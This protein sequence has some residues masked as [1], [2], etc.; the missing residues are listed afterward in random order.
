MLYKRHRRMIY[1][2]LKMK[3]L[4][5]VLGL[6]F[7]F[8][9]T[10]QVDAKAGKTLFRNYCAQCHDKTMVKDMTGPAL[11]GAQ[12]RWGDDEALYGWI[13]NSAA[14]IAS[15]YP[16]AVKLYS[17]WDASNMTAFPDLTDDQVGSLLA[18]VNGVADGTFGPPPPPPE[19]PNNPSSKK[20]SSNGMWYWILFACLAALALILLRVIGNLDQL[21]AEKEGKPY[22]RKSL[23]ESITSS[24]LVSILIF[25]LVILAGYTTVNN[26][27]NLG[28]QQNYE[29]DQPIAFSH[30]THAGLHKI[31]CQY[32][33][34]GARRSKHAVIPATNT[35]MNCHAAIKVGSQ[36]GTAELSK[37]YA[38]AGWNP[39]S[40]K[41]I[42]GYDEMSQDE[43]KAIFSKWITD[44]YKEENEI[45][46]LDDNDM[47]EIESQWNNIVTSLT[48]EQKKT[49]QGPIEWTRVHNLPDHVYFNHAQHVTAGKIECQTCHGAV[50]EMEVLK[51]D[52]PLSMGWCINC[53]RQTEVQ[54]NDNDYY[55]DYAKYH[56]EI[57]SGERE[58]VT[59]AD[60]GGLECQKCHY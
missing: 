58:K 56:E 24:G 30:A 54:F 4:I 29:P 20:S 36:H 59:V 1:N 11:A 51:Q 53:H 5:A 17:D 18:Y 8:N 47:E 7:A 3:T 2:H 26:A 44:N 33:H 16:R 38:S 40:G 37:V 6:F 21:S 57:K 52:A 25:A 60:I 22:Q 55:K 28:R 48:N 9:L 23:L 31:E 32:C 35:C 14:M 41:Y 15:G 46:K 45:E 50:E 42:E 43:I 19:D 39:N 27:M 49:V 13:R 34:D 12:E 10:A